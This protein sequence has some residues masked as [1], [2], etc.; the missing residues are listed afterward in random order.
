MRPDPAFWHDKK[1]LV[2][3]HTGFKGVWLCIWLERLG[4]KVVGYALAPEYTPNLYY[5]ADLDAKIKSVIGDIRDLS[6]LRYH[7]KLLQPDIVFHLAAQSLVRRSYREPIETL[8]TNIIGTANLLEVL[9]DLDSVRVCQVITSDKCYENTVSG[10]SFT[11]NDRLGGN[12]IYSSSKACAELLAAAYNTSFFSDRGH[13]SLATLRAGNVIGGGDWAIDRIVPDCV[14]A[15]IKG[16]PIL[17]RNPQAIRPWQ[18]VLEPLSAYLLLAERQWNQPLAYSG[19]WNIGPNS[20]SAISVL[21]LVEILLR[22][23]GN[24]SWKLSDIPSNKEKPE[25]SYLSLDSSKAQSKLGWQPRFTI[26]EAIQHTV[27]WY[28][29]AFKPKEAYK[30]CLEQITNYER[31]MRRA[32]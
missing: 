12:D 30:L 4:A 23:W 18:H 28:R 7:V 26:H 21:A 16:E 20:S 5:H 19:A 24:G 9:R 31:L 25:A 22:K 6:N 2:T 32:F 11:E 29:S 15:L 13:F 14:R 1:V 10:K 3:G 17:L 8:Q 27:T